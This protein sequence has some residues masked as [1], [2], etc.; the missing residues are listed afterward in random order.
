MG[1]VMQEIVRKSW[2]R[3]RSQT[4]A[5]WLLGHAE[6]CT[7]GRR[8]EGRMVVPES[9]VTSKGSRGEGRERY[10]GFSTLLPPNLPAVLPVRKH[11]VG[12]KQS[13]PSLS[14][15]AEHGQLRPSSF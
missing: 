7:L 3:L 14:H 13:L 6:I 11:T 4:V 2:K 15:E 10:F 12:N 1:N 5:P 9:G 8:E